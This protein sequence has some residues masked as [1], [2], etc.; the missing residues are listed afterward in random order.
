MGQLLD[1]RIKK[2]V[3]EIFEGLVHPV[4]VLFFESAD[5]CE[6][7]AETRQLLEEVTSLSERLELRIY[8][9]EDDA[10]LAD[11]Y[12]V[13]RTPGIVIAG[14]ENGEVVHYGIHYSGIPA[15]SEFT[16]LIRDLL[17]VSLRDSGLSQETREFLAGIKK[18][19]NLQ[20][21]V[22]PT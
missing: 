11:Q 18:P 6:Y 20:V 10:D 3:S 5:N 17:M 8:N 22:T 14:L 13:I 2:Q 15:G 4:V 9:L 1:E 16:S 21:F 12:G 19:I 7:C